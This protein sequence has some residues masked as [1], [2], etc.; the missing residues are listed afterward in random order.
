VPQRLAILRF[1]NLSQDPSLDWMGRAFP[2]VIWSE[3]AAAPGL[4]TI[5]PGRIRTVDRTMGARPVSAPGVSAEQSGALAAGANRIGYGTYWIS[6]G[7]LE[8]RLTIEDSATLKDLQVLS[9]SVPAGDL[10]AAAGALAHQISGRAGGYVTSNPQA[11]KD[12]VTA[13]EAADPAGMEAQASLA[14]AA[15]PDFGPA[16]RLL[17]QVQSQRDREAALALAGQALSRAGIRPADRVRL[18]IEAATLHDD[19]AAL[20]RGLAGLAKLEPGDIETWQALGRT[21]YARHDFRPAM[22]AW[23]KALAA[24]PADVTSLNQLGYAAAYAGD[25]TVAT[26]A[27]RRY[28][29]LRPNDANALDSLGDINFI[30]GHLKEAENYYVQA[31][32]KVPAFYGGADWYKAAMA[33]LMTGD[34]SGADKLAGQFADARS[35]ARDPSLPI[36]NA[37]WQWISGRRKAAY[38]ALEQFARAAEAGPSREL[39]SRAYSQLTVWSLISGDPAAAAPMSVKAAALAGQA[40]GVEA[41]IARFLAQ[42][43]ATASEWQARAAR[44]VPNPAQHSIRDSMVAYALLLSREFAPASEVLGR[45]YASGRETDNEGLPALL[46]W[47]YLETGQPKDA[48]PLV[49]FNPVPPMTGPGFLTAFYFPRIFD[50]RARLAEKQGRADEAKANEKLFVTLSGGQ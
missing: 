47:S 24:E 22:E 14:I 3:L 31:V 27:L 8:A 17:V 2:E 35:A 25:W 40:S 49:E 4:Y 33:R 9:A 10:L 16:Y 13:L 5:S 38:R 6:G 41:A 26:S 32:K 15:D 7:R 44:L 11:L 39:A 48:V 36:F 50:L 23:E 1:E 29:V 12:Y 20:Q 45:L 28:A 18:E 37:E 42:P 30:T 19:P 21:A 46:A 34:I 43:P